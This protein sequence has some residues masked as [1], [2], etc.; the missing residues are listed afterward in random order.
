MG[1][2]KSAKWREADSVDN[3]RR[4]FSSP[5]V[6][7]NLKSNPDVLKDLESSLAFLELL[8]EMKL[9]DSPVWEAAN[10]V[11]RAYLNEKIKRGADVSKITDRYCKLFR[12][13]EK[14]RVQIAGEDFNGEFSE[15]VKH[16]Y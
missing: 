13:P 16:V 14:H 5:D 10:N 6:L 1:V 12:I 7:K 3:V 9:M 2:K 8:K 4:M 15:S 11:Y